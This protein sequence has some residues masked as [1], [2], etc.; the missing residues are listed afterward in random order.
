MLSTVVLM[1]QFIALKRSIIINHIKWQ[2]LHL[3]YVYIHRDYI[4]I[5]R[6]LSLYSPKAFSSVLSVIYLPFFH[7]L[8]I[9]LPLSP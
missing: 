9:T 3:I 8:C 2:K 6:S 4:C 5:L 1:R 7:F